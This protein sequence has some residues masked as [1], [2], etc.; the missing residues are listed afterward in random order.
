MGNLGVESVFR[1]RDFFV[2]NWDDH[3]LTK[4]MEVGG[5]LLLGDI[6]IVLILYYMVTKIDCRRKPLKFA[7][8]LL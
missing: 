6:E 7:P 2:D 3:N 5:A 4:M 1:R 8:L